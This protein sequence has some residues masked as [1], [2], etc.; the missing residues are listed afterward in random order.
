MRT[1]CSGCNGRGHLLIKIKGSYGCELCRVCNGM[2]SVDWVENIL[3]K[4]DPNIL[5]IFTDVT[6]VDKAI[7][8]LRNEYK[9][10][11]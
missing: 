2:G 1:Q 7:E 3:Q 5:Q 6:I 8:S 4:T 11:M 9:S 10:K